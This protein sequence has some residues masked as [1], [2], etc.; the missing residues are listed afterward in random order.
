[1]AIIHVVGGKIAL[2]N[3]KIILS[4]V[5]SES[6]PKIEHIIQMNSYTFSVNI[7]IL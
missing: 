1:M 7:L 6:K 2:I 3:P 4:T 5:L